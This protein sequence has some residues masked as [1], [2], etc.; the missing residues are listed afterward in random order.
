MKNK[1]TLYHFIVDQ[2]GSMG[3]ME[4][5]AIE[6]FNTQLEKIQDLEKTMPEQKFLCSLTFFNSEVQDVLKNEPVKQIELLSNNNYR[7]GGMTALLD[8]VGGSIDRIQKQFGQELEN[9]EISIVMVIITDGYENASK[10]FTYHMVAQK[11]AKLDETGKWTFSYLGADFDAIHTSKMM[12]IRK[13]NAMNFSKKNYSHMMD[14]LSDS[15]DVY[16]REKRK[17]NL[18]RDI[19]DIFKKKDRR[20]D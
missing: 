6:G 15:I 9:D 10:Y 13:E 12:N 1:T 5:Q 17:G 14:D 8:A 4:Q 2:S 20:N 19:L 16:A 3:G 18:K 7:P 11:I